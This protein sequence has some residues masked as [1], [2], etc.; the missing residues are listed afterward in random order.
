LPTSP[1]RQRSPTPASPASLPARSVRPRPR[2]GDPWLRAALAIAAR[3][4]A[5]NAGVTTDVSPSSVF[6]HARVTTSTSYPQR[7]R[8]PRVTLPNVGVTTGRCRR[9]PIASVRPRTCQLRCA[10]TRSR[11]RSPASRRRGATSTP[12][13]CRSLICSGRS[14]SLAPH[15]LS[16]RVSDGEPA[17]Q[18]FGR[19]RT[20]VQQL[21]AV[22]PE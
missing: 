18:P 20:L 21:R 19:Q 11:S 2:H 9:L 3:H 17:R 8:S 16:V 6:S 4:A 7:S 22:L 5:P 1:R 13:P 10:T 12:T 14:D 15:A